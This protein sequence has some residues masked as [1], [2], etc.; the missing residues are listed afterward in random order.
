MNRMKVTATTDLYV[1][2]TT[3]DAVRIAAGEVREFPE[4]IAYA[5]MQAGAT[6]VKEQVKEQVKEPVRARNEKG[7]LQADDPTTPDV[8]EAWEGGEAPVKKK[9]IKKK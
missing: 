7:Q 8:N 2:L 6:E 5:C 9:T 1:S 3:G 4:Y